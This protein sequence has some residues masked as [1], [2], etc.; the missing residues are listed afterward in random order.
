MD[1]ASRT[2]KGPPLYLAIWLV[3]AVCSG[4]YKQRPAF[5]AIHAGAF[6]VI[7]L[8]RLCVQR[9]L[10]E[11]VQWNAKFS[12]RLFCS[13]IV[14]TGLY[15]G[16]LMAASLISPWGENV[17][18]GMLVAGAAFA[19]AG[20]AIMSINTVLCFTYPLVFVLPVGFCAIVHP[21]SQ[22]LLI[23]ALTPF[24]LL[25]VGAVGRTLKNDYWGAMRARVLAEAKANGFE[26]LS[27]TDALT[28]ISN[29]LAFDARLN[30]EWDRAATEGQALSLLMV[31]LDNFKK[32]N[33]TYGHSF[34][35]QC[36]KAA[37][38]ALARSMRSE[39]DLV[40]RFGGEEF[41]VLLP[42]TRLEEAAV[43]AN[44]CLASVRELRVRH[45]DVDVLITCSIGIAGRHPRIGERCIQ[46]LE[47]ADSAMYRA[48]RDGR[49]RVSH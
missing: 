11:L 1:L 10:P 26:L 5:V 44:R 46:L 23:G 27:A 7:G 15:W 42:R 18:C 19:A 2:Q 33:D 16:C 47:E 48:K 43:I 12:H 41:V 13:L 30:S 24:F 37:A 36:L 6:V 3:I 39:I 25:Y 9:R 45:G 29:R 34:G 38:T 17:W 4:L 14:I 32:L 28:G 8:V 22:D 20:A 35:D 49:D 40:A 21:N 31:D